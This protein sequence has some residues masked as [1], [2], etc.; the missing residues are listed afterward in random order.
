MG[1]LT[2]LVLSRPESLFAHENME[3]GKNTVKKLCHYDRETVKK[4]LE[5]G[6]KTVPQRLMCWSRELTNCPST[7]KERVS[8]LSLGLLFGTICAQ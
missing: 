6:K 3:N 7:P 2:R 5:N 1:A 4:L 8:Y